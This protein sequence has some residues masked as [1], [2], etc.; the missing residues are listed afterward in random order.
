MDTSGVTTATATGRVGFT[1]HRGTPILHIDFSYCAYPE[2][3]EI[4]AEAKEIIGRQAQDSLF[5]LTDVTGMPIAQ[6]S[7]KVMS[8]FVAHNRPYV[9]ASVVVGAS[10]LY[11]GILNIISLLSKRDFH[12]CETIEDARDWLADLRAASSD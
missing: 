9:K 11:R 2:V 4:I 8:E 5:I 1:H 3:Q 12:V 10:G 7:T 6:S